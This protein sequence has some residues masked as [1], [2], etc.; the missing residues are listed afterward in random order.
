MQYMRIILFAIL[1]A[2]GTAVFSASAATVT[3]GG[4]EWFQPEIFNGLSWNTLAASLDPSASALEGELTGNIRGHDMTGAMWASQEDLFNLI[5]HF[6]T[7]P[8]TSISD[9]K[10]QGDSTWMPSHAGGIPSLVFSEFLPTDTDQSRLTVSGWV[11]T[12]NPS[13]LSYAYSPQ[14]TNDDGDADTAGTFFFAQKNQAFG[15]RGAW[16][17]RSV[18]VVPIPKSHILMASGL[19]MLFIFRKKNSSAA[20]QV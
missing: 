17:Y 20:K 2:H 5:N 14:V 15:G 18:A 10:I 9:F 13:S 16:I 1:I 3:I 4:K 19:L 8:L 11:R 12:S 7:N 6:A